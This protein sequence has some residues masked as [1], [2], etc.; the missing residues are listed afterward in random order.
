MDGVS[1]E[2][3]VSSALAMKE[4]SARLSF[5]YGLAKKQM[6]LQQELLQELLKGLGLGTRLDVKA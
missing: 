4:D 1:V 3:V 5:Q 2:S 6:E